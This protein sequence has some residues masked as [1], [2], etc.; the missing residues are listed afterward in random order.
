MIERKR[1]RSCLTCLMCMLALLLLAASCADPVNESA[2][3]QAALP[4]ETETH[5]DHTDTVAETTAED[6]TPAETTSA[7]P[8]EDE[9]EHLFTLT[10]DETV[11]P[12]DFDSITFFVR[13]NQP[14]VALRLAPQYLMY[15]LEE[16]GEILVGYSGE[17]VLLEAL[18]VDENDYTC[19]DMGFTRQ[20]LIMEDE[21]TAGIYRIYHVEARDVYVEFELR[22]E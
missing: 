1:R 11:Y 16:E 3:T 9:K 7:P 13:S 22:D 18:P 10:L 6:V 8:Q 12:T 14:G 17:E 20:S 15:R 19:I 4:S 21:F 2:G 5:S